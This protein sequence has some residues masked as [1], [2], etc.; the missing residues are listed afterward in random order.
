MIRM[1]AVKCPECDGQGWVVWP[2]T[3]PNGLAVMVNCGKC[4]GGGT[5][6]KMTQVK[7]R[8]DA[9]LPGEASYCVGGTVL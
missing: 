4:L 3:K 7:E 2:E 9:V 1:E 5:L 6:T 8:K